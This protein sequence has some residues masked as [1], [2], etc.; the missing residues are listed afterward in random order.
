MPLEHDIL[1]S[2]EG[3]AWCSTLDLQSGYW[4]VEIEESSKDMTAFIT[5]KGYTNSGLC[6]LG[7]ETQQPPFRD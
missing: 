3:A 2:M 7:S 5:T 6:H 1:E 4:Q